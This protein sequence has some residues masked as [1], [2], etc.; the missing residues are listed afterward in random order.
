MSASFSLAVSF[1]LEPASRM[2]LQQSQHLS[3]WLRG[4]ASYSLEGIAES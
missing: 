1:A 3:M 4:Q 2:N